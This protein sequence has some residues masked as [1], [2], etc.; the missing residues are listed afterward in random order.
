M[1]PRRKYA[2]AKKISLDKYWPQ[3]PLAG[4]DTCSSLGGFRA[5]RHL[6]DNYA[7]S[8]QHSARDLGKEQRTTEQQ[9][10]DKYVEWYYVDVYGSYGYADAF[11][12]HHP[13]DHAC[14]DCENT[15]PGN[16]QKVCR[17]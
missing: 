12:A 6:C 7:S 10:Q 14:A 4:S 11:G 5:A 15:Q 1:L 9:H 2:W 16:K 13:V 17:G 8:D 3:N